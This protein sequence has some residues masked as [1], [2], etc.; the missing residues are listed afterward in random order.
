MKLWKI[1]KHTLLVGEHKG[2]S[3]IGQTRQDDPRK[4]WRWDGRGYRGSLFWKAICDYG[5][6]N[7]SHEIIEDNINT[8]EKANERET[9]WIKYYNSVEG[10]WNCNYGGN[11]QEE[12]SEITR[13][14][15]SDSHK[16]HVP[17]NK[18]KTNVYSEDVKNRI[19]QTLLGRK[20]SAE[21]IE[22]RAKALIGHKGV[23]HSDDVRKHLSEIQKNKRTVNNGIINKVI[24]LE[25]LDYYLSNG[26][27]KGR[28][29]KKDA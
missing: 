25:E 11:A 4:R 27:I 22:K 1:Y 3:Y 7:F 12:L 5:W 21:L 26:W 10:G 15:L 2:W 16:G 23:V 17:W 20:Q 8:L 6:D 18:G 14:K 24:N 28:I 29:K 13:K 9:Y 19:R